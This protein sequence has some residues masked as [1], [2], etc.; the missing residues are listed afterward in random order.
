MFLTELHKEQC[1]QRLSA[2]GVVYS[3][4][5]RRWIDWTTYDWILGN[6]CGAVIPFTR[7]HCSQP[8]QMF[9][10]EILRRERRLIARGH[11]SKQN[12]V[13]RT[14]PK[15]MI[16]ARFVASNRWLIYWI[17]FFFATNFD[18]FSIHF[19]MER[20]FL[21]CVQFNRNVWC[22]SCRCEREWGL[23]ISSRRQFILQQRQCGSFVSTFNRCYGSAPLFDR[24]ND[25]RLNSP[26]VDSEFHVVNSC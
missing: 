4:W 6:M 13:F 7:W 10:R 8:R 20:C 12:N 25:W 15:Q 22:D 16:I 18:H 3:S 19:Q 5:E 24:L 1:V 2:K 26:R 9:I 23:D 21:N 17:V 14:K 11:I